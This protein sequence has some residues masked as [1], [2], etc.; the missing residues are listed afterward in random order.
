MQAADILA[1]RHWQG[2]AVAAYDAFVSYSHVKDKP[3]AAALQSVIQKLGKPWYWRKP[4]SAFAPSKLLRREFGGVPRHSGRCFARPMLR[5]DERL[6]GAHDLLRRQSHLCFERRRKRH[7]N[8][9]RREPLRRRQIR[10][11]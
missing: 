9:R 5:C 4:A 8:A 2:H 11:A 7:G 10:R 1:E 3:V 6:H